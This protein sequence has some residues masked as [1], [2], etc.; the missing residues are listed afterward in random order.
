MDY[1]GLNGNGGYYLDMGISWISGMV[2]SP[3]RRKKEKQI[4]YF[5]FLMILLKSIVK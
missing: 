2:V 1:T 5:V 4:E 3:E